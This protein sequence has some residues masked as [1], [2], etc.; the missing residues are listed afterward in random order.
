MPAGQNK[1]P[2]GRTWLAGHSLP[3]SELQLGKFMH[4]F[5]SK[6]VAITCSLVSLLDVMQSISQTKSV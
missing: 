4:M 5:F 6:S 2:A 3:M 1:R